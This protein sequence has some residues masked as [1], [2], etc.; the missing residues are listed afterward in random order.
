MG[1]GVNGQDGHDGLHAVW[2][3]VLQFLVGDGDGRLQF[4]CLFSDDGDAAFYA[5]GTVG[6]VWQV[7]FKELE[8]VDEFLHVRVVLF[9]FIEYPRSFLQPGIQTA[10][11]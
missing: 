8:L 3:V 4:C 5:V 9:V 11:S 7:H 10:A 6:I 1:Y 2:V